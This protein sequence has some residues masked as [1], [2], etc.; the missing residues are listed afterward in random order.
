MAKAFSIGILLLLAACTSAPQ[1]QR[2]PHPCDEG[3]SSRACQ[4]ERYKSTP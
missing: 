2:A 3:E 1:G 4:A